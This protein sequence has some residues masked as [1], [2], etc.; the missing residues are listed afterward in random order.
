M[1]KV[2][3]WSYIVLIFLSIITITFQSCSKDDDASVPEENSNIDDED[4]PGVGNESSNGNIS[5][6]RVEGDNIVKEIDYNV[7]GAA[8]GFQR[9]TKKHEEI[10][11][12]V[13]KIVPLDY[14]SRMSEFVIY[15]GQESGTAGYVVERTQDLEKWQMGIAIDFAYQGGFNAG[16]ELA[17]T[18]VHEFGHI[19]TLD[20]TQLD[21]SISQNN[22]KNYFPGEGCSR[23]GAL[24]NTLYKNHWEDIWD[25]YRRVNTEEDAQVFYDKYRERFVTQYASTN[26]GEDIAEVFAVFVTRAGSADGTSG[27]EQKIQIMYDTNEMVKLRNYIRGNIA[28]SSQNF[29]PA[30]GTWKRANTFGNKNSSHCSRHKK[31]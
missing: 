30:P 7:T 26:P 18:I 1:K 20:K 28:K 25:E 6:Y 19:L 24:I 21:S 13:K 2:N 22:C 29:L 31:K 23:D 14:R 15:M 11:E 8:L 16:G 12:L 17:Y 27:A 10:W 3:Q 5:L 4:N 9:D